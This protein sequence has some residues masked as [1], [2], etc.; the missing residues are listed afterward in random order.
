MNVNPSYWGN[1]PAIKRVIM[2]NVSELAN[3]Q[4]A[5][6]TGEADIVQDLSAEQAK[7]LESNADVQIVK[8]N[9]TLLV[10]AGMNAK[11]PPLDKIEVREAI[12]YAI[13][14][15]EIVN[16]LLG[17]NGKVVQEIIPEGFSGHV[18]A[19]PF[20]PDITL[21]KDLLAKAGVK[22]GTEIELLI[23]TGPAPGGVE[24]S[25][26][27]AK[28]QSDVAQ[29]GLKLNIKQIQTSE[30]LNIYRAQ[31]GQIVLIYWGP[32]YPDPDGN[33]NP[34]TDYASKSI[35]Y[36]NGWDAPEIANLGKQAAIEQ[37]SAKRL[38]LYKQVTEQVLHM[39][40]YI[41]LYQP[42]RTYGVRKNITGFVS[43]PADTPTISFWLIKKS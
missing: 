12:R 7:A 10:Y 9:S 42:T 37:D 20:K 41:M 22:D 24:F 28:I 1:A 29:I 32:D 34:F 38:E 5:L 43:D 18:G 13:N 6:E 11:S 21:A 26:L 30:L 2:T 3:L 39:G 19:N 16:N 31:K 17:G 36:R 4:S 8:A 40:P 14:Y 27:G 23:P 35:A 15:D 33:V 25:T